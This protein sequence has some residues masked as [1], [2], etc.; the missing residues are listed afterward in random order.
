MDCDK[1]IIIVFL[2][3]FLLFTTIGIPDNEDYVAGCAISGTIFLGM[4]SLLY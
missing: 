3:I 4:I 1:L 2:F